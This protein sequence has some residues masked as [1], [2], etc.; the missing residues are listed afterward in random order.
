MTYQVLTTRTIERRAEW[1]DEIVQISGH[2][3]NDSSRIELELDQ[4]I[5]QS[6]E[7]VILD[8][9]RLA[10]AIPERYGHDSSEEK[11]YSKYTDVLLSAAF[12]YIG[13]NSVVLSER[14]DVA[15]VEATCADYAFVADAKAFRLS[16]TAKNQKD[17]KVEAMHRWKWGKPHAMVVCPIY[18]LPVRSSQIYEQAIRQTV[19]IFTYSH[20]AVLV[21]L[22]GST[23][24]AIA[25]AAMHQILRASET[26]NPDKQAQPYWQRL[27]SVMLDTDPCVP[28][29][30]QEEKAAN[31][32]AI[33]AAR[34]EAMTTLAAER[35]AIMQMSRAEAI[36]ALMRGQNIDGRTDIIRAVADNNILDIS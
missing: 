30:W 14:A 32:E 19:C 18:Q 3:G 28:A 13:L 4:R 27:N 2:F 15:D 20:L 8:H 17:F 35:Q 16:R 6:G 33:H 25:S 29:L 34:E 31:R 26:L 36:Q 12:R 23:S 22:A 21:R 1:L 10:G 11:L 5:A 24:T 7:E 9:L